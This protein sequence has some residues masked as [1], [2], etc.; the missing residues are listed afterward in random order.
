[1]LP[2]ALIAAVL[3]VLVYLN[4]QSSTAS[5]ATPVTDSTAPSSVSA[6]GYG[7]SSQG[8][9]SVSS[10]PLQQNDIVSTLTDPAGSG[11]AGPVATPP[12]IWLRGP[13]SAP[14][15]AGGPPVAT[16]NPPVGAGPI[17]PPSR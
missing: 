8:A 12:I 6:D 4:R 11:S 2:V 1:M 15:G 5:A 16:G 10:N 7:G 14:V 13:L 17:A 3:G 9:A